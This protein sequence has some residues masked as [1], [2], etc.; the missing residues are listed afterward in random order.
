LFVIA[1]DLRAA[2]NL[3]DI[4]VVLACLKHKGCPEWIIRAVSE[5]YNGSFFRVRCG[6]AK[7]A[8]HNCDRGLLQGSSLSPWLFCVVLQCLMETFD[9]KWGGG[10]ATRVCRHDESTIWPPAGRGQLKRW[11]HI[12]FADDILIFSLCRDSLRHA[13]IVLNSCCL[14]FGLEISFSKCSFSALGYTKDLDAN[15]LLPISVAED[16]SASN[17]LDLSIQFLPTFS[18]LGCKIS[19]GGGDY[20]HL[21]DRL[22][23]GYSRAGRLKAILCCRSLDVKLRARVLS[24]IIF[25]VA[26]F[27]MEVCVLS[28]KSL[29]KLRKFERWCLHMMLMVNPRDHVTTAELRLRAGIQESLTNIVRKSHSLLA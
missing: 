2:Y 22:N 9:D 16:A 23:L 24:S 29:A 12:C 14:L 8:A 26:L 10:F 6:S 13:L 4:S 15:A 19:H 7:S 27:G 11:T 17:V 20:A 21:V 5:F 3:V 18:Y 28:E 25:P 1:I